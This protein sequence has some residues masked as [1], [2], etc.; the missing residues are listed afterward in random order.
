MQ[1]EA[2]YVR[3]R[4]TVLYQVP[5]KT[6]LYRNCSNWSLGMTREWTWPAKWRALFLE[7]LQFLPNLPR[8]QLSFDD[9]VR[10]ET[11]INKILLRPVTVVVPMN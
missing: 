10:K 7:T 2:S 9:I 4:N 3:C 1:S 11:R 8:A 6:S 5:F